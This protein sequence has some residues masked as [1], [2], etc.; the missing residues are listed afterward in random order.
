MARAIA[1]VK[2]ILGDETAAVAIGD[3]LAFLQAASFAQGVP[4][5]WILEIDQKVSGDWDPALRQ[6]IPEVPAKTKQELVD[7]FG[8]GSITLGL[9]QN[10]TR[11]VAE[12]ALLPNLVF[13]VSKEEITGNPFDVINEYLDVGDV[14]PFRIYRHPEGQIRL[15]SNDIDDDEPVLPALPIF[16]GGEP[17]LIEGRDVPWLKPQEEIAVIAEPQAEVELEVVET[18]PPAPTGPIPMP[19]MQRAVAPAGQGLTKREIA[20]IEFS[21]KYLS[22]ENARLRAE[23]DRV[24]AER[25]AS[26]QA[27][28]NFKTKYEEAI[29]EISSLRASLS[30]ARKAKRNQQA[31]KSTTFS[32]RARFLNDLDW[33]EEEIRRAWIGRYT[34]QERSKTYKLLSE[35]YGYEDQFFESIAPGKLDEDEIRKL[36]RVMVDLITGRNS[37]EHKHNVHELSDTLG[38]P[39]KTRSDGARCW[40]VHIENGVP[41]AKRLHY[42]QRLDGFIEFGWV[43]NHDEGLDK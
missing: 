38:G 19:G 2:K 15:K 40:R 35:K 6:F 4:L 41:Q 34:P 29:E 1:I 14:V 30:E 12:I 17:W 20:N 18:K 23:R 36:I 25:L 26:D 27:A 13:E 24:K 28:Q 43:A 5:S 16:P 3:E 21:T 32:R 39:Q 8:F 31:N 37:V 22:E 42:W 9:V 7:H 10:T 33:F 11:K